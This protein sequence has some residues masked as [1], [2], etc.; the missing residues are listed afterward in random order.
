MAI[1]SIEYE[2]AR[3][4]PTEYFANPINAYLLVKRLTADWKYTENLLKND[5]YQGTFSFSF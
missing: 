4:D 5:I 1:Y 2:K 3:A